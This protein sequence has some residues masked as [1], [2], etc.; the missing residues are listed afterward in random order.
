MRVH[1]SSPA[2]HGLR[3]RP[4]K[5]TVR[6]GHWLAG[7][8]EHAADHE[9]PPRGW[10][11]VRISRAW[12]RPAFAERP[13]RSWAHRSSPELEPE[14]RAG[15]RCEQQQR[16]RGEPQFVKN[17][18]RSTSRA[19]AVAADEAGVPAA[20]W[21]AVCVVV[22]HRWDETDAL[23]DRGAKATASAAAGKTTPR[24]VSAAP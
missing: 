15:A 23:A 20:N 22:S 18:N 6:L 21:I 8:I 16:R 2:T 4:I 1:C 9:H 17:M 10:L 19:R 14:S 12:R 24:R 5:S 13:R 11:L 3:G 7:R